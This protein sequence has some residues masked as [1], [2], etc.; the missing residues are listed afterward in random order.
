MGMALFFTLSGFLIT[1][2][3]LEQTSITNF[4]IRRFFRIIPLAWLAMAIAFPLTNADHSSYV[5]NFL[6]YAN[7]PPQHLTDV[8]SHFWSLCVEMQFYLGIAMLV[9]LLGRRGLYL[10]PA[11]CIAI[12]ST[13]IA[14]GAYVDIVTWRRCDE[15]LAGAIL[16]LVCAGKFGDV[17]TRVLSNV[18]FYLLI[19]LLVLSSHPA[20]G[21]LNYF[22]PYFSAMLVGATLFSVP[23]ALGVVLRSRML[24][25][26]AAVS[27]A[28]Y[29]IHHLLIYSWLGSGEKWIKYMKRPLLISTTFALAHLSTFY[30]E[31]RC[32]DFGKRLSVWMRRDSTLRGAD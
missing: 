32:T 7:L 4:L 14:A 8:A 22:R 27:F 31:R 1:R 26:I 28:V 17:P 30:F 2:S 24:A 16:A 10:V 11:L 25:Y 12:T 3:L 29:V 21:F 15:I 9:G 13:R 23:R 6:F 20:T 19:A 18:N 5:P